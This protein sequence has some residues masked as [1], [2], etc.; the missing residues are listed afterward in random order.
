[1]NKNNKNIPKYKNINMSNSK[2]FVPVNI[3]T[4]KS[5]SQNSHENI[6]KKQKNKNKPTKPLTYNTVV[7]QQ[8]TLKQTQSV[9]ITDLNNQI[10]HQFI[11]TEETKLFERPFA[12]KELIKNKVTI[13]IPTLQVV[14]EDITCQMVE[15]ICTKTKFVYE[16]IIINNANAD[17]MTAKF[18]KYPMVCV[19][20]DL[21]NLFV[22]SAWN[23]GISNCNTEF[24]CL[25]NDDVVFHPELLDS[26]V[27][28][29]STSP[30]LNVTTVATHVYGHKN[31]AFD[32]LQTIGEFKPNLE[33]EIR[34]Y[35]KT[36][37]QGWFIF[38]RTKDWV[39]VSIPYTGEIMNGDDW[40]LQRNME[41][42]GSVVLIKNNSLIHV[43]SSTVHT[44]QD[45]MD[46]IK[47]I[48]KPT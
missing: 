43:E 37:K 44:A 46:Y 48:S 14:F 24:Y 25:L 27:K 18:K 13:V 41:Q 45:N 32:K 20:D 1:M 34:H 6:I 5:S 31:K 3:N 26:L 15:N 39:P 28:F 22:N 10:E 2:S 38:G 11:P 23:Y 19:V 40:I 7:N 29:L 8:N 36:I 21:P 33:H 47:R 42:Y 16:V 30:H 35:P 12:S 4:K 9:P 17:K